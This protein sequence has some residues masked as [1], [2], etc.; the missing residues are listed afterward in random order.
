MWF[1]RAIVLV[2][3]ALVYTTV[4]AEPVQLKTRGGMLHG[5][6]ETPQGNGPFPV[7]LVIAGS[8]PTDRDG[9]S[10]PLKLVNNHLKLLAVALRREGIASLRYDKRGVGQS[11]AAS[12][13]EE[14]LRFATY[15]LDAQQWGRLLQDD[16][17]FDRLY[18]IGHSEGSLV[19]M[20]V[21][22][23]LH[24]SG[25]ISIAGAGTP[26]SD[27]LREQLS[28]NLPEPLRNQA[29]E[30]IKQLESGTKVSDVPTELFALFRP[31]VQPYLIS[32]F[33]VDPAA[34]L[35]K[36]RCRALIVDGTTDIQVSGE[37][38]EILAGA[39]DNAGR[40]QIDG[41]NHVLKMVRDDPQ[42]QLASYNNPNLPAAEELV[43]A[44]SEF[45][46]KGVQS[47]RKDSLAE[48]SQTERVSDRA[49]IVG[50]WK[51]VD[52]VQTIEEFEPNSRRFQGD[53]VLEELQCFADG[54]I[55]TG[56]R[57]TEGSIVHANGQTEAKY[58]IKSIDGSK[59]LFLPW[60]SGD[61]VERG[62]QPSYYVMHKA[63]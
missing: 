34:E 27:V 10:A 46:H 54:R 19:G 9:N 3:C 17:R 39:N 59:Y 15:V 33:R 7:A 20:I 8:G 63:P 38:A 12:P 14:D 51:S 56:F 18:V 40:R 47:Q 6:L 26:A 28:R 16:A 5:T 11:A 36:L 60:L 35:R 31:S 41:M 2:S 53:L 21:A 52:F 43:T 25:F 55:S 24:A 44:I 4:A 29:L 62:M 37:H 23:R 22:R 61:V 58:Y 48:V 30:V 50:V 42:E 49:E 1:L 57:W 45:V 13:N 32:W